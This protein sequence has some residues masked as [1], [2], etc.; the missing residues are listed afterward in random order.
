MNDWQAE[1]AYLV[2]FD[3]LTYMLS[4]TQGQ[5]PLGSVYSRVFYLLLIND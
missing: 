1:T 3:L 4:S 5:H 2:I